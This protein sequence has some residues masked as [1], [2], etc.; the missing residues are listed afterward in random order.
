MFGKRLRSGACLDVD[1]LDQALGLTAE[2][3]VELGSCSQQPQ[4]HRY[5]EVDVTTHGRQMDSLLGIKQ[6]SSKDDSNASNSFAGGAI[7]KAAEDERRTNV[8]QRLAAALGG[9]D[10]GQKLADE[11]EGALFLALKPS[12]LGAGVAYNR[13]VRSLLHN[14]RGD[15]GADFRTALRAGSVPV[16]TLATLPSEEMASSAKRAERAELRRRAMEACEADWDLRHEDVPLNGTFT[17]GKCNGNRTWYFQFQ[18]RA[19]DEPM[20]FF[21]MCR[22][23]RH[24]WR[25]NEASPDDIFRQVWATG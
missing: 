2:E 8:R 18:T 25:H 20:E 4:R 15:G 10:V 22:E 17:C 11:V 13:Q 7:R 9:D 5:C 24:G 14:L 16:A 19:C 21:V 3:F 12:C 1:G 23:C 6:H